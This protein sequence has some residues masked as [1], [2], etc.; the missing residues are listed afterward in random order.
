MSGFRGRPPKPGSPAWERRYGATGVVVAPTAAPKKVLTREE[1]LHD[2]EQKFEIFSVMANAIVADIVKALL[3]TGGPGIGKTHTVER[4]LGSALELGSIRKY[5]KHQGPIS[6]PKLYEM[7]WNHREKGQVMVLDDSDG[8]WFDEESLSL[9]KAG[10]DTSDVR[11]MSWGKNSKMFD[12]GIDPSFVFRG[13][14]VFIS[15]INFQRY[16]D[17]RNSKLS[18]HIRA[19]ESRC[20]YLDLGLHHLNELLAWVE[21]GVNKYGIMQAYGATREQEIEGIEFLK[22]NYQRFRSVS[23]R[24]M[25]KMAEYMQMEKLPGISKTWQELGEAVLFRPVAF[26]P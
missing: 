19:V 22:A 8:V 20:H 11:R 9:L 16:L 25:V 1:I 24:S 13:S 23:F 5:T 17:D 3:V 21:Y 7:F 14:V 2:A 26:T 10:L 15:N 4:I 6:A 12:S 18:D